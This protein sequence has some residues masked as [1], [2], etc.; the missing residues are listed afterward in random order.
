VLVALQ[1]IHLS[2]YLYLANKNFRKKNIENSSATLITSI[3][4]RK[5]WL[6]MLEKG[7]VVY[8]LAIFIL[9]IVAITQNKLSPSLNYLYTLLTSIGI[10][11]IAYKGILE[12]GILVPHFQRKYQTSQQVEASMEKE[13]LE[14]L[15]LLMGKEKIYK[16]PNLKV[17]DLAK[18]LNLS[19][20]Q[21]SRLINEKFGKSFSEYINEHRVNEFI[22]R[23]QAKEHF[24]YSLSG[25]AAEVGFNSKSTFNSTFK[26]FT[27]K[28]PSAF[29]KE[30]VPDN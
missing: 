28:T 11:I 2:V 30:S 17:E 5:K 13:S 14:K 23:I 27:G 9:L 15:V 4:E 10:Y 16:N 21:L 7:F 18:Q 19:G 20:N 8:A 29:I 12:P 24:S 22:T 1:T 26:K 25:L 3:S 6:N